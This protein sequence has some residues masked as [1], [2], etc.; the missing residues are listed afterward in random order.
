MQHYGL[1]VKSL[2]MAFRL[3]IENSTS[4]SVDESSYV[5]RHQSS[6]VTDGNTTLPDEPLRM[7]GSYIVVN[8]TQ[9]VVISVHGANGNGESEAG[10]LLIVHFDCRGFTVPEQGH[11]VKTL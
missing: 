2:D 7:S 8:T 6:S 4:I 3:D 5:R 11:S 9:P 1:K 10:H